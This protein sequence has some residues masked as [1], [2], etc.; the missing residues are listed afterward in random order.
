M[1]R[2]IRREELR[3]IVPLADSTIYELE[4]KGDFPAR[5]YLTP[6][7]VAWERPTRLPRPDAD[8]PYLL[9]FAPPGRSAYTDLPERHQH[10]SVGELGQHRPGDARRRVHAMPPVIAGAGSVRGISPIR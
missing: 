4:K 6:R 10:R 7:T 5:F 1:K 9:R 2:A 8:D 3:E